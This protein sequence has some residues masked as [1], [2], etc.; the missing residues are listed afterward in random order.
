[1]C[2]QLAKEDQSASPRELALSDAQFLQIRAIIREITGI[3]MS[4]AKR[5]LILRRLNMRLK[6]LNMYSVADYM[7]F[8]QSGDEK[9]VE[10]FTNAVTT[11]LTSFFRENH[12]FD[13]LAKTILPE[14]VA[15][16]AK[17]SR[18]L[19]IWSAGCSTGEEPY[20]IAMTLNETLANAG[21]WDAK[22]LCTDI[23][24]DVVAKAKAGRYP[25][26]RFENVSD[27]RLRKWFEDEGEHLVAKDSLKAPLTFK[28]LNLMGDWPMRGKFDVIFCRNVIIY[29]DKPTQRVLMERYA[30]A[31]EEGGYLF[32]GHSESLFNVSDRFS[33]IGKTIY[34]KNLP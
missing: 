25:K 20:S 9:E 13:Y 17:S 10:M 33:L 28:Q 21:T 27:A 31:L 19:R 12:H 14:L 22:I 18:R 11:N 16:R 4:D 2:S 5:Q 30:N 6:A 7:E 26:A 3:T 23:D 15:N 32:L 1:M 24:T 29:F 34:K 8:L